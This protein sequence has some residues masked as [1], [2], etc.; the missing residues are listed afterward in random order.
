VT[1]TLSSRPG[2]LSGQP[3]ASRA[4]IAATALALTG[5]AA[6]PPP[7]AAP[8]SEVLQP[9]PAT[10]V[11]VYASGGQTAAQLDRDRYECHLWAV[12]QARYD[13]SL[14]D[15]APHQRVEVV[16]MPPPGTSTLAGAATGA[17][18]GAAVSNP[19]H[20]GDGAAVG[21]VAGAMLGAVADSARVQEANRIN[22]ANRAQDTR[23]LALREE[24]ANAYRRAV[25]ACLEGRDYTVK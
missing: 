2:V 5:C 16:A 18:I 8:P 22:Q 12:R 20:S 4:L 13:P 23:L 10:Q 19:Y 21:A 7:T 24:Q 15:L 11:F 3:C 14:P 25:S 1:F 9:P 6:S 17:I